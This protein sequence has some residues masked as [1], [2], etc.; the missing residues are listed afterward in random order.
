[1][2]YDWKIPYIDGEPPTDEESEE[3]LKPENIQK[4]KDKKMSK[5]NQ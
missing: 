2:D 5:S 1:M 4:M 3:M